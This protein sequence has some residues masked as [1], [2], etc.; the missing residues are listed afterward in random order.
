MEINLT[1]GSLVLTKRKLVISP[2]PTVD[3]QFPTPY[4][5]VYFHVDHDINL[6]EF[7][8]STG[9]YIVEV[10]KC[11]VGNVTAYDKC[12]IQILKLEKN[13]IQFT[14]LDN[15]DNAVYVYKDKYKGGYKYE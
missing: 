3:N 6:A 8:F 9:C 13:V 12:T 1:N 4:L 14:V 7:I 15:D 5:L 2:F 11:Y 10:E